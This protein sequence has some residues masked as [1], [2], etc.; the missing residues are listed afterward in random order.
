[1]KCGCESYKSTTCE[2]ID[3]GYGLL[4]IRNIP[5]FK[6]KE[7]D[8]I[9]YMGDVV[10]KIEKIKEIVEKRLEDLTV[11]DYEKVA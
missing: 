6:C 2:A 9:M 8:E 5:C 11:I 10:Q 4:V 3:M 7:C 1:M